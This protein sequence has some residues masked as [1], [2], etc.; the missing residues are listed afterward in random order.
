MTMVRD[1]LGTLLVRN[2]DAIAAMPWEAIGVEGVSHKVLWQSGDVVIGLIRVEAGATKPE[3]VHHGAH[4][5]I[6]ITA[7]SCDMVG[8][9]VG[10]G[11]YVYIPPGV[12]HAVTDVGPEGC[13]FF[14]TYRPLEPASASTQEHW[15]NPV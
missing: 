15:G 8:Q 12:P 7:G 14:Y 3:H 9:T 11:S 1:D 10:S 5:H 2:A 4:H 6:W 13:E